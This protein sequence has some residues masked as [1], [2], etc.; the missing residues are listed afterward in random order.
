M[1]KLTSYDIDKNIINF[2]TAK[3]YDLSTVLKKLNI[4]NYF[5]LNQIHS[6][7][8]HIVDEN[9]QDK[10]DGDAFITKIP[11]CALVIRTADCIPMVIYDKKQKIIGAIHSGWKGTLNSIIEKTINSMIDNFS[12]N[13]KDLYLYLYPSIQ[14]CHF[15]IG[16]DVYDQFAQKLE[17]IKKYTTQKNEKYYLDLPQIV[18]DDA[19]KTG[20]LKEHIFNNNVCTYCHN[21]IFYSYRYNHTDKRN[22]L[23]VMIKG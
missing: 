10:K 17:N 8:V 4:K 14:K 15:E 23:I 5:C 19:I 18:I 6:N 7:I 9:Y 3:E 16:K 13:P 22:Y 12:S 21:D 20:V 1:E 2:F 11:N